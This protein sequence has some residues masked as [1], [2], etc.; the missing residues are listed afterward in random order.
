[1]K[2]ARGIHDYRIVTVF[3]CVF[4]GLGRN[5]YGIALTFFEYV[6][7]SFFADDFKLID[8]RGAIYIARREKRFFALF[9]KI[10]RQ[11]SAKGRFTRALQTAH[12]DNRRGFG[13]YDK[14]TVCR[15]HEF[16]KLFVDY[17]YNLLRRA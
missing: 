3:F 1:M 14:L 5:F 2:P 10:N 12:H 9:F 4:D 8:R 7:L 17:F 11:L 13:A 16:G 6:R 15:T